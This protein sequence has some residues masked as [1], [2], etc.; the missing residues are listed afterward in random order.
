MRDVFKLHGLPRQIISDRGPQFAA[1]YMR[2]LL[3]S[4]G[5]ESSLS[6]AYHPRTD[7]QT[8][9]MNQ[10]V[11]QYL[12]IYTSRRQD[13][14]V[15]HLHM[16]EFAINSREHSATHQSPFFMLYGYHPTFQVSV[17]SPSQIPAAD[18][19][20]IALKE[21]QE[22]TRGALEL[23]AERMKRH[24]DQHVQKAPEYAP[25]DKVWIDARNLAI[26]QPSRKLTHKRLGPYEIV[27]RIGPLD[28]EVRI[29]RA[30]KI[31]PVFHVELLKSHPKDQI[32][33]RAP[34]N[35][36][37]VEIDGEEEFEV[38]EVLDARI[39][40]RKVEYLV[41]WKGYD[42]ANNTWEPEGN[43]ENAQEKVQD[44]HKRHPQAPKRISSDVFAS[45]PWRNW[46]N[47]TKPLETHADW[48]QGVWKNG[49]FQRTSQGDVSLRGGNVRKQP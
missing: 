34:A 27:R 21:V 36:P 5:V 47:F 3:K 12:R 39:R 33:G 46:Q 32:P 17:P 11:E 18:E 49:R 42:D 25:G 35:P 44:F 7:G 13:D 38:A 20:L 24:F 10:E 2:H 1:K 37:P 40:R 31:H 26:S 41:R 4:L 45:L 15:K 9:R 30:W 14:W 48:E 8:E 29:P 43:L 6:T 16:A 23:A 19:R 28:Y 22:D